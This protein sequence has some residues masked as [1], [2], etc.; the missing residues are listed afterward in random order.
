MKSI[1]KYKALGTWV[2]IL[3][4]GYFFAKTLQQNWDN[5][6]DVDLS[7][8]YLSLLSLVFF[9]LSIASS[10]YLWGKIVARLSRRKIDSSEAVRVHMASWLL[11]YIPGQAGSLINKLAWGKQNKIDGKL[12]TASFIYENVFLILAS[13]VIPGA[14][15]LFSLSNKFLEGSTIFIPL[16]LAVPLV[17]VVVTPKLFTPLMNRLFK[18]VKK[19]SVSQEEMLN[20]K[21]SSRLFLEF[22]VPRIFNGAAFVLVVESVINISPT[23]YL[24]FAALYVLAGIVGVL[25]IFV[26]SGLGVREAV[27]VLFASAYV[28]VEQAVVLALLARFYATIA[29]ILVAFIYLILNKGFVKRA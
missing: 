28:P 22:H 1:K 24:A 23:Q 5:L 11:K 9:V 17:L 2:I 13:T 3:L 12:I 19:Q 14:I 18:L 21:E 7:P 10:G 26:P 29:D 4:T 8:N 6:H 15:L 20:I 16:L 25:A 27:I